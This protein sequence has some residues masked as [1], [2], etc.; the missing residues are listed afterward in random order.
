[1][2]QWIS[3]EYNMKTRVIKESVWS[4]ALEKHVD[5]YRVQ[6]SLPGAM[7]SK[8]WGTINTYWTEVEAVRAAKALVPSQ[9][10]PHVIWESHE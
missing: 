1:M 8:Y 10:P 7:G 9:E 3:H 2:N 4:S 6:Q 5:Q